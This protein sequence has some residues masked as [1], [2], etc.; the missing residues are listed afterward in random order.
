MRVRLRSVLM[1]CVLAAPV[2]P[3]SAQIFFPGAPGPYERY[4][5]EDRALSPRD[6]VR[7]LY[8]RYGMS[9]VLDVRA[10]GDVYQATAV[11]RRGMTVILTVD[12]YSGDIIERRVARLEG[13]PP[14]RPPQPIPGARSPAP[15]AD[16]ARPSRPVAPYDLGSG[17]PQVDKKAQQR[18]NQQAR[19][20]DPALPGP[21]T[22][23]PADTLTV[24][25]PA[26]VTPS[27]LPDL[28]KGPDTAARP[29]AEEKAPAPAATTPAAPPPPAVEAKPAKPEP[30]AQ[31]QA[32]PAQRLPEP[33]IDPKTGKANPTASDAPPV[34]PLDD[35]GKPARKIEIV[36]PAGFD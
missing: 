4:Y 25:K 13:D 11:D 15:W 14:M 12:A 9:R 19:K 7:S 31:Q 28:P 29:P 6:V 2:F 8:R 32:A 34:T 18:R 30:P 26:P 3:A 17:R 20:P 24:P 33:L 16:E 23:P 22:Q 27:P 35:A 1:A 36:P 10:F 21:E 5:D